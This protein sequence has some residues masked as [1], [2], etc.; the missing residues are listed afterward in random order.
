MN[1]DDYAKN[2]VGLLA[3]FFDNR[4][5]DYFIASAEFGPGGRLDLRIEIAFL[6]YQSIAVV[7]TIEGRTAYAAIDMRFR[8]IQL[9]RA[10]IEFDEADAAIRYVAPTFLRDLDAELKLRIP[11]KFLVQKGWA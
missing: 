4:A 10:A 3:E 5:C 11:D 9:T 1:A 7:L 2:I 6:A 8:K